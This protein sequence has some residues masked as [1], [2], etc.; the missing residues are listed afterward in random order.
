MNWRNVIGIGFWDLRLTLRG[1]VS[2]ALVILM[3]VLMVLVMGNVMKPYF[4]MGQ[5]DIPHFKVA[6]GDM[7][8]GIHG[9]ALKAFLQEAAMAILTWWRSGDVED[10]VLSGD[11]PAAILVLQ[12]FPTHVEEG[13]G[14]DPDYRF[15]GSILWRRAPPEV[16]NHLCRHRDREERERIFRPRD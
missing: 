11:V 12:N 13:L 6:Y 8:W 9:E 10:R 5:E 3:P 1:R 14:E 2:M 7:G 15:R 16:G 4:E